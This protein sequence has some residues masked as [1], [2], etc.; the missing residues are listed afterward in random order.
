[1]RAASGMLPVGVRGPDA[2][3]TWEQ[4]DAARQ[5]HLDDMCQP[6]ALSDMMGF[7]LVFY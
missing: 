6:H 5:L 1:M 7:T 2:E 4:R 3:A